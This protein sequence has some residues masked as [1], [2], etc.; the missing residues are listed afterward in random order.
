MVS[1]VISF[2]TIFAFFLERIIFLITL[3]KQRT[4]GKICLFTNT[5]IRSPPLQ[6]PPSSQLAESSWANSVWLPK[7][8]WLGKNFQSRSNPVTGFLNLERDDQQIF[9]K[10]IRTLW[11]QH[12]RPEAVARWQSNSG[13][14]FFLIGRSLVPR[15][16]RFFNVVIAL[17]T[18]IL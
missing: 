1:H 4:A 18:R 15:P 10:R 16:T 17:G 14:S 12:S 7:S 2:L 5:Y 3:Y 11:W 13:N 8:S 9:R 6:N